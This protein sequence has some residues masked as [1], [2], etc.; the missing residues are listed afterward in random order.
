MPQLLAVA[1]CGEIYER[2]R[3]WNCRKLARTRLPGSVNQATRR[4]GIT[5]SATIKDAVINRA[6]VNL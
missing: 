4:V 2:L 6:G 1:V 3:V 5:I